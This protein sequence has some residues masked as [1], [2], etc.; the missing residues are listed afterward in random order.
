MAG[1]GVCLTEVVGLRPS[2]GGDGCTLVWDFWE[3]KGNLIPILGSPVTLLVS[4][5]EHSFQG[6]SVWD[7]HRKKNC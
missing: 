1:Q 7:L 2:P 3:F 4:A 5:Q 6:L